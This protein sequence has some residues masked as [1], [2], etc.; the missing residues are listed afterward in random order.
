MVG[1]REL[2]P[3]GI[4][5][6]V[7]TPGPVDTENHGWPADRG[8]QGLDVCWHPLGRVGQPDV[9]A[10][11]VAFLLSDGAGYINGAT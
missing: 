2:G 9:I 8:A 5:V 6:N 1:P 3:Y 4:M 11:T 10:A 7:L